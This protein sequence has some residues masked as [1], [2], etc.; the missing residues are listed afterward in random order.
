M[1]QKKA[2]L[3]VD[4]NNSSAANLPYPPA[5]ANQNYALQPSVQVNSVYPPPHLP[6]NPKCSD[7]KHFIRLMQF[8]FELAEVPA[9]KQA[10]LLKCYLGPDGLA[11]YDG[12][13]E[14]KESLQDLI[15]QFDAYFSGGDSLL[16]HRKHFLQMKQAPNESISQFAVR[17]RRQ[18][19]ICQYEDAC[20]WLCRD[21]FVA[22]VHQDRI[23]E[24]LLTEDIKKLTFD[25]AVAKAEVMER[26]S[27]DRIHVKEPEAESDINSVSSSH[28]PRSN[29]KPTCCM[30]CGIEGSHGRSG[31]PAKDAECRYC[32]KIGHYARVC[33]KRLSNPAPVDRIYDDDEHDPQ[34]DDFEPNTQGQPPTTASYVVF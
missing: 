3:P 34:Q 8:H 21:V 2:N 15:Q 12:L 30:R 29:P 28:K 5:A 17:L 22:G 9:V 31:C 26:A 7:W 18:A 16:L 1:P 24:R 19:T 14:P 6:G 25:N 27:R 33:R 13:P 20:Q 32:K 4:A 23:G 10:T 11:I